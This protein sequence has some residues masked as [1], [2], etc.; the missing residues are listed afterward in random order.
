MINPCILIPIYN[1][2]ETITGVLEQ[3]AR[4]QLPCL[5]VDDG[6]D[7]LTRQ[8]LAAQERQRPWVQVL[9]RPRNGGKGAAVQTGLLHADALGYSHALQIDADG[10]HDTQDIP[11]FLA[12]AEAHPT[13]LVLG[14]PVLG[15][16]A[17]TARR[18]GRKISQFW[19]WVETLS[20]AIGDPLFGF[21]VYPVPT[22]A[23]FIRQARLGERMDFDPEIAVRLYW[24]NVP[25]RNLPTSVVYPKDGTSHFL[26]V[27]DNL[28]L[29]WLHTRLFFGML[30]RLPR[31]L[32]MPR[33]V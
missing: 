16:D 9:S 5:I 13:A 3:V 17:P 24:A 2:K 14:K 26:A 4:F 7:C 33:R 22:V 23:A 15:E 20:L 18:L 12:E 25:I 1:H 6:S 29:S 31:L 32:R 10:Q 21:R 28:L 11:R 19:V 27:Y 8:V 30:G